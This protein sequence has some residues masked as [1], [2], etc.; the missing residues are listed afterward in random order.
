MMQKPV[1]T[2][3]GNLVPSDKVF[4][5]DAPISILK[6]FQAVENVSETSFCHRKLQ[7]KDQ[8]IYSNGSL[9]N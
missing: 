2:V 8:L 6:A 5:Q 1:L 3:K 7:Y 9:R 4:A